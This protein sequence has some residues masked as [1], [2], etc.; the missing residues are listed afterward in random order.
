[1]M[2][3]YC[4]ICKK[5]YNT[6]KGGN[7]ECKSCKQLEPKEIYNMQKVLQ[8]VYDILESQSKT[9]MYAERIAKIIRDSKQIKKHKRLNVMEMLAFLEFE[10]R[11]W[12]IKCQYRDDNN[13]IYDFYIPEFRIAIEI[14][15]R[16]HKSPRQREKDIKRDALLL[17]Q[18]RKVLRIDEQSIRGNIQNVSKL[19]I[20][21]IQKERSLMTYDEII[22]ALETG[23]KSWKRY[24]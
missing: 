4:P 1:M 13:F 9:K 17:S 2:N 7:V 6:E 20:K 16:Y 19:L 14:D 5:W 21:F 15:E 10:R 11:G 24:A 22:E 3:T 23:G 18:Y 8:G 12:K